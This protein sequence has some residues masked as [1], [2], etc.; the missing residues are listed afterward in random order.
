MKWVSLRKLP[1]A[2][3]SWTKAASWRRRPQLNCLQDR[4]IRDCRNSFVLFCTACHWSSLEET[5]PSRKES[6]RQGRDPET[7]RRPGE[8]FGDDGLK[9]HEWPFSRHE[10]GDPGANCR[11]GN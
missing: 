6:V 11:D 10:R 1:I 4:H 8:G 9:L 3:C 2:S 5:L 7:G